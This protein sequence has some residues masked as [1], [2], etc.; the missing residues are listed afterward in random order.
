MSIEIPIDIRLT[1]LCHLHAL[2]LSIICFG[3]HRC[4]QINHS[5]DRDFQ[6]LEKNIAVQILIERLAPDVVI[7]TMI[8]RFTTHLNL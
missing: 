6:R 4:E 2:C 1:N 3:K 7:I 8:V 5:D